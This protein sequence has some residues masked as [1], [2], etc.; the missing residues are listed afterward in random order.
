APRLLALA[1][2][3]RIAEGELHHDRLT[4]A[5]SI[6]AGLIGVVQTFLKLVTE[7]TDAELLCRMR[8]CFDA[9]GTRL[10]QA[11]SDI[12]T[13]QGLVEIDVAVAA[14]RKRGIDPA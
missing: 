1:N 9:F 3:F 10:A 5:G 6:V 8:D 12:P 13:G 11:Y 14:G 2:G 4:G 7:L